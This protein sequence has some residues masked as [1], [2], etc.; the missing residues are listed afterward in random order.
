MFFGYVLAAGSRFTG[1]YLVASLSDFDYARLEGAARRT[2]LSSHT[3]VR[4][5]IWPTEAKV[6]KWEF[7]LVDKYKNAISP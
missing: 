5:L 4:K 6:D 2:R 1:R 7:P 3:A